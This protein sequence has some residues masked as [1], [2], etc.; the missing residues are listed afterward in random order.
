MKRYSFITS[1]DFDKNFIKLSKRDK[2]ISKKII[3]TIN[4]LLEEPFYK[5]IKTNKV[6]SKNY[7]IAYSSRVT[8]DLRIIWDFSKDGKSLLAL[9]LG[10]H[11]GNKRVYN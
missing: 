5:G 11:S 8:G 1:K 4:I 10:G 6:N 3:E 2:L 9:T 7:G